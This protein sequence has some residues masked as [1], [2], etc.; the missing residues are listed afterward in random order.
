MNTM[1]QE[2]STDTPVRQGVAARLLV[3]GFWGALSIVTMWLAVLFDGIFGG[4]M[5][6]TNTPA[7]VTTMP[8]AVA[9]A[10]F[11]VIGTSAVAKRAFGRRE[12][13]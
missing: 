12:K 11:A 9:V 8:S 3:P 13:D 7:N 6:F 2:P 10:L 5:T 1:T 4:D